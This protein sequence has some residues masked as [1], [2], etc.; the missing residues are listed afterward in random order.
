MVSVSLPALL[1]F[2]AWYRSL[3]ASVSIPGR[4]LMVIN[5]A[6]SSVEAKFTSSMGAVL[7][8]LSRMLASPFL[9]DAKSLTS[10]LSLVLM[11]RLFPSSVTLALISFSVSAGVLGA[12]AEEEVLAPLL[13]RR[14]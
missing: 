4:L 9:M 10:T 3:A 12:E 8:L 5:R 14:E 7:P 1:S 11:I 6:A 13:L 2:M